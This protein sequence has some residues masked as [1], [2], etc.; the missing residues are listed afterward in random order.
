MNIFIRVIQ[1]LTSQNAIGW[2][3]IAL[4]LGLLILGIAINLKISTYYLNLFKKFK[5]FSKNKKE[6]EFEKK[7]TG[8]DEIENIIKD[9]EISAKKGTENI[10]TEV[11]I[12]KHLKSSI[13]KWQGWI[14]ILPSFFIALG[15]LGTFL[16]LTL[17]IFDTKMAL[18]SIDSM[19]NFT[20]ALQDPISSMASAFWTSIAGV[21]SSI[22]LNSLNVRLENDKSNFEDLLEDYL[23]NKI[24]ADHANT[25]NKIFEEFNVTVKETMLT[26]TVE[27]SELFK[28]GV[29]E[30]VNKINSNSI[31]LTKSAEALQGYT[32]EFEKLVGSLDT[33]ITKF[34]IPVDKFNVSIENFEVISGEL[35]N[36]FTE[37]FGEFISKV[38]NLQDNF[39]VLSNSIDSNKETMEGMGIA[40]SEEAE[41]LRECYRAF[42]A[43]LEE[44]RWMNEVQTKEF[45]NQI[46]LVNKGY[47][48][49]S[50]GFESFKESLKTMEVSIAKG[51]AGVVQGELNTLSK[52]FT[53]DL[54]DVLQSIRNSTE[55]LAGSIIIVGELVKATNEL[56]AVTTFNNGE[57]EGVIRYEG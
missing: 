22:I 16:G 39:S 5:V 49:F 18:N 32:V 11:I 41:S 33:T 3:I 56:V 36:K 38:E 19:S 57:V 30:L 1:S 17:A 31:D 4:I 13:V 20:L 27:M 35:N 50:E 2:I 48:N 25:F 44:V 14:K 8:S 55:E 40:I 46:S 54:E 29:E 15:L 12:Q 34:E 28:N 45:L 51:F 42:E 52:D 43:S 7:N 6:E 53:E 24:Y 9:F 23:D 37:S 26:L 21:I 10:N 47:E